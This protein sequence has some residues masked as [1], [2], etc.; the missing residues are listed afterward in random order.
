MILSLSSIAYG[1]IAG[2]IAY[3][4]LNGIPA[5]IRKLSGGR[6]VPPNIEAAEPWIIPPGGLVP[7]WFQKL[8]GRYVDPE[9]E[10]EHEHE[11]GQVGVDGVRID[12]D[13]VTMDSD[14]RSEVTMPKHSSFDAGR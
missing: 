10:Y 6:I 9:L 14:A 1:V 13:Q 11:M 5:I 7:V 4:L 12:V 2:V 3:I 8:T